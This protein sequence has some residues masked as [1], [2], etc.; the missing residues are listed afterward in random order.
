[1]SFL[2]YLDNKQD[3]LTTTDLLDLIDLNTLSKEENEIINNFKTKTKY[4]EL[5]K[6]PIYHPSSNF[7]NESILDNAILYK[8]ADYSTSEKYFTIDKISKAIVIYSNYSYE[9]YSLEYKLFEPGKHLLDFKKRKLE[10][11]NIYFYG[12]ILKEYVN[13]VSNKEN[14]LIY[15]NY[16]LLYEHGKNQIDLEKVDLDIIDKL[17][18]SYVYDENIKE[19]SFDYISESNSIFYYIQD[20][21]EFFIINYLRDKNYISELI[22]HEFNKALESIDKHEYTNQRFYKFERTKELKNLLEESFKK[23]R[24]LN[25]YKTI[26]NASLLAG[27]TINVNDNKYENFVYKPAL[28]DRFQIGRYGN[29][30]NFEDIKKIT[31]GRKM[32]FDITNY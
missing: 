10:D 7:D 3:F 16:S 2:N 30:I 15:E 12:D 8:K 14:Q 13:F 17:K 31:F 18:I 22:E 5:A 19:E 25:M 20:K 29:Y 32:L 6:T 27:K 26:Y 28:V 11:Y 1:M 9:F 24:K 23:D 4:I 21:Y